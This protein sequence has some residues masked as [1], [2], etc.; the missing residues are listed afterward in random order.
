M[1][2]QFVG[3]SKLPGAA[4]PGTF[5]GF[6][7]CERQKKERGGWETGGDF[8]LIA[9]NPHNPLCRLPMNTHCLGVSLGQITQLLC[10]ESAEYKERAL[11]FIIPVAFT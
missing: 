4:F 8:S 11:R 2:R 7:S 1:P 9:L 5:V 10:T 6:F 3:A